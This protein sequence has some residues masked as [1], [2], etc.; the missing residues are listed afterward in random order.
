M[1]FFIFSNNSSIFSPLKSDFG[2]RNYYLLAP[3]KA[4]FRA[5]PVQK[6]L[7]AAGA[8]IYH[9]GRGK[10]HVDGLPTARPCF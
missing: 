3:V 10:F 6:D 8:A 5:N 1:S 2:I 7:V 4:A 9:R